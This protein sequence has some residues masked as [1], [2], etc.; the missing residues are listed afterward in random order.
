M[1]G[2]FLMV[3]GLCGELSG[4]GGCGDVIEYIMVVEIYLIVCFSYY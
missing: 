1:V 2:Q 4:G 3:V